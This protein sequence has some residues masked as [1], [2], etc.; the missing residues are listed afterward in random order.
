M[1]GAGQRMHLAIEPRRTAT[2]ARV[3][4]T[5][6]G[7]ELDQSV[8][9]GQRRAHHRGGFKAEVMSETYRPAGTA[10]RLNH[11]SEESLS[12]GCNIAGGLK[13]FRPEPYGRLFVVSGVRARFWDAG[14]LLGSASIEVELMNGEHPLLLLFPADIG[15]DAK[16]LQPE[17]QGPSGLY[18]PVCEATYRDRDREAAADER[19]WGLRDE[20]RA[21]IQ[22]NGAL[23]IPSF[24]IERAQALIADLTELMRVAEAPRPRIRPEQVARLDWHNDVSRL[25]L[26]IN[27][28]LAGA[29]DE[30]GGD[31]LIRRWRR[32]LEEGR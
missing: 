30:S 28:A 22:P 12:V 1:D 27:E 15:P 5:G 14:H 20:V 17:P 32:V 2:R 18:Y 16:L 29:G 4:R 19:L 31:V 13:R 21:A 6:E 10:L 23:L 25:F 11:L 9:Y 3:A 24:A 26:D 8:V 7:A